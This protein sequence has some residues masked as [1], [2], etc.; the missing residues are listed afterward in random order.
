MYV[1][2]DPLAMEKCQ[3]MFYQ[4][5]KSTMKKIIVSIFPPCYNDIV[6]KSVEEKY[7]DLFSVHLRSI[8]SMDDVRPDI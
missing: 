4:A 7:D 2:L 5:A 1:D 3:E 6:E 8:K